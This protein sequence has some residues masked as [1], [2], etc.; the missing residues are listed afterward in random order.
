MKKL[1][2]LCLMAACSL[3]AN[4]YTITVDLVLED[5][6][7][8]ADEIDASGQT[9]LCRYSEWW[10]DSGYERFYIPL[11]WQDDPSIDVKNG[12]C[13][14]LTGVT[15][16]ITLT[17]VVEPKV[18]DLVSS[19]T[20]GTASQSHANG[21]YAPADIVTITAIPDEG[22]YLA[23]W[24][25]RD[26][27]D[28]EGIIIDEWSAMLYTEWMNV[29]EAEYVDVFPYRLELVESHFN[30][31]ATVFQTLPEAVVGYR[32]I[33]VFKPV[34]DGRQLHTVG[35]NANA[36]ASANPLYRCGSV[37]QYVEGNY[38]FVYPPYVGEEYAFTGWSDGVKDMARWEKVTADKTYTANY[39]EIY[40]S[41]QSETRNV[42]LSVAEGSGRVTCNWETSDEAPWVVDADFD[43]NTTLDIIAQPLTG[44]RF[45]RWSD[46][47][48]LPARRLRATEDIELQAYFDDTQQKYTIGSIFDDEQ[49]TVTGTGEYD[50]EEEFVLEAVPEDGYRFVAWEEESFPMY[51][52]PIV[53][54]Y[55][56]AGIWKQTDAPAGYW[57]Y[58]YMEADSWAMHLRANPMPTVVEMDADYNPVFE[59]LPAGAVTHTM[60]LGQTLA[61]GVRLAGGGRYVEGETAN[62]VAREWYSRRRFKGWSDGVTDIW[63]QIRMTKD[64]AL[65]AIV[66]QNE[67]LCP[68]HYL[69][70]NSEDETK[71]LALGSRNTYSDKAYESNAY[72]IEAQPAD[73]YEFDRWND[74]S[75]M[76]VRYILMPA[77]DIT[78]T[79][80][81][82][83]AEPRYALSVMANNDAWGKVV[84]S[85]DYKA[86]EEVLIYAVP[87]EG[88]EFVQWQ[89][90][91]LNATRTVTVSATESENIYVALFQ[92]KTPTGIEC[93]TVTG[94]H[95]A[96]KI[97]RNGQL[98]ILTSDGILYNTLG[99]RTK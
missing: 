44:T 47:N 45:V 6:T 58:P 7:P 95:E 42:R 73:G 28:E 5:G 72:R 55:S 21:L 63:R 20:G 89:D 65:T 27:E 66:E 13:R 79:A 41:E 4:A 26:S 36:P 80:S 10:Y 25:V 68:Q 56:T 15:E 2:L 17:L 29:P 97:L 93:T 52:N 22:W 54:G 57:S 39:R 99:Q 64:S 49:G 8:V 74:G 69:T 12:G 77:S 67:Y 38:A 11:Y 90:G 32:L 24:E 34:P 84:G 76:P 85:G 61:N 91:N 96:V 31:S 81:F 83:T 60:T 75:T 35:I 94:E 3:I 37:A 78:F 1:L 46:G 48:T 33:P 14:S 59:A 16:D 86:G 62:I 18:V 19:V 30:P 88:Y 53:K 51:G 71:G 43:F 92:Q 23:Y 87:A 9:N 70:V 40:V 98:L 82:K 50:S